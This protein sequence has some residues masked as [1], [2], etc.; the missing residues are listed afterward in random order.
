MFRK[1]AGGVGVLLGAFHGWLLLGQLWD[2]QLAEPGLLLRW[3]V[4][5]GL[6][7]G[8]AALH[9]RGVSIVRGRQAVALWLL[10]ALLHGPAVADRTGFAPTAIPESVTTFVQVVAASAA[11]GLGLAFL[12]GLLRRR[13]AGPG[14]RGTRVASSAA[15]RFGRFS[16][17]LVG[18]RPPP[19]LFALV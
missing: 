8:L 3:L 1:W 2:G 18:P 16:P 13:P 17:T 5:G 6:I 12:T 4:A 15:V 14:S 10:A 9:R 19:V 11:L 7:A